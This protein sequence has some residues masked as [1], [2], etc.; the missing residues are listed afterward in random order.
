MSYQ[1]VLDFWFKELSE[2][3]WFIKDAELDN[4]IK[5]RFSALHSQAGL[6]ELSVWRE[7]PKGALA[8]IILLD[9]FSRNMFRGNDKSF[10]FDS[11]A[12]ILAQ[13]M[14]RRRDHEVLS[15]SEFDFL[16]MPFMHSESVIVHNMAAPYFAL[17]NND[18]L[19]TFEEK[20]FDIIKR[21]GRYPHRNTLLNRESTPE[22]LAFLVDN[23]GF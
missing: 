16:M 2:K 5:Q 19:K 7:S 4:S 3:Q 1:S 22:E 21:F 12:L 6:G 15:A 11:L 17:S 20:Y 13:E 14:L 8:E 9:Q 18:G 23:P 10:A